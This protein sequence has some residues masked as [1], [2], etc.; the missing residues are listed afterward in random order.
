[1]LQAIAERLGVQ[2]DTD[3]RERVADEQL[4]MVWN[5][6]TAATLV[7]TMFAVVMTIHFG[8]TLAPR[9]VYGWMAAKIVVAACR[10]VQAQVYRRRGSPGGTAWRVATYGMLALDG[11]VW[12]IAAFYLMDSQ[13]M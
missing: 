5:H 13:A 2:L 8:E 3:I 6:A 9:L 11:A 12:G 1:M 7:A 10:V 4:R